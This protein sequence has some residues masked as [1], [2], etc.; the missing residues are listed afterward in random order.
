MDLCTH[1]EVVYVRYVFDFVTVMVGES[2]ELHHYCNASLGLLQLAVL[3]VT[4][5]FTMNVG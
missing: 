3:A 2:A 1:G 4:A 5:S